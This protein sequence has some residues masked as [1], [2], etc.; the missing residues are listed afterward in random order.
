M[1]QEQAKSAVRW[2]IATFGPVITSHGYASSSTLEMIGGALVSLLP[3][4]WGMFT[5]T[6]SNAVAVVDTIAK[7]PESPVKGIVTSSSAEGVALANSLP[8]GETVPAGS[9]QAAQIAKQGT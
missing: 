5:H 1:N 3:L 4:I 2:M 9:T 7:D 6:E 8:G